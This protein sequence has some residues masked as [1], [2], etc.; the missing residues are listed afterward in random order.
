MFALLPDDMLLRVLE[1]LPLATR[2][3]A[4]CHV[5]TRWRRILFSP[6]AAAACW[7][8]LRLSDIPCKVREW[9]DSLLDFGHASLTWFASLSQP[10]R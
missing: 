6:A 1:K 4:G 8:R 9:E 3:Y 5:C 7:G 10:Y 2:V